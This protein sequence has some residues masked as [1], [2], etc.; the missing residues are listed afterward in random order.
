MEMIKIPAFEGFTQF[1]A[2]PSRGTVSADFFSLW[3]VCAVKLMILLLVHFFQVSSTYYLA[4]LKNK[5]S[6]IQAFGTIE[7][8][9]HPGHIYVA[10][11]PT[12]CEKVQLLYHLLINYSI[13]PP[14]RNSS[15]TWL[16]TRL[17]WCRLFSN[18]SLL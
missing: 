10:F 14:D 16:Y 12:I 8:P 17:D 1:V 3:T 11:Q 5:I 15:N 9:M 18:S 13:W 7:L 6:A 2:W 4:M